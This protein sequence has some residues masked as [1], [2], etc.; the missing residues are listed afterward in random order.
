MKVRGASTV[1]AG[2]FRGLTA[3]EAQEQPQEAEI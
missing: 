2:A 1:R 3:I